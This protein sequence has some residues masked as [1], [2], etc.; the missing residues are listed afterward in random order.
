MEKGKILIV[1]DDADIREMISVYFGKE[2]YEVVSATN[3][4][5]GLTMAKQE[6]FSVILLDV[7]M[8]VMNGYQ[9]LEKLRTFSDVPVILLTAKGEQI[10]KIQ[11]FTKGCDDYVVKPFDF[12]ELSLRIQAIRKRMEGTKKEEQKGI[13]QVKDLVINL[14][15]H[16]VK[17]GDRE[18]VLTPKEYDLLVI[19][20]SNKGR[21]FSSRQLYELIWKEAFLE[22]DSNVITH[23]RNLREK[24]G[25]KVKEGKYIKTIW[26]V[27]YKIEKDE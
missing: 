26:G 20:A 24:L 13:L 10:S 1:D 21:V 9:M 19:L 15:E 23:M 25:D 7:M 18:I 16:T 8:P 14:V 2:G 27:G 12:A 3:G 17:Q 5:Q 11:G 22:N 6:A 4:E